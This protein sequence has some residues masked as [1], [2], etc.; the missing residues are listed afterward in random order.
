MSE[1]PTD[2]PPGALR[3]LA[4]GAWFV[5]AGFLFLLRRPR[6]W[7]FALLPAGLAAACLAAGLLLGYYAVRPVSDWVLPAQGRMPDWLGFPL[8][9]LLWAGVLAAGMVLG[10]AV[11]LLLSAPL[12][13]LL[14]ARAEAT[15]RGAAASAQKGLRW[16]VAQSLRAALYFMARAPLVFAVSLVPIVGP[17]LGA[18]LGAHALA[19]QLTD[20]P[21]ARRGQDFVARRLWHRRWRAESVGFGLTGLLVLLVPCADVLLAP[22]LVVGGALLILELEGGAPRE[23]GPSPPACPRLEGA[24]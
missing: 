13:E 10:L 16:E 20:A 23:A 4:A 8:T 24:P 21:L 6:L 11:A 7:P 22:A 5:P 18:L 1:L 17:I 19:F 15:A 9:V 12:L 3:R 2:P 14:S